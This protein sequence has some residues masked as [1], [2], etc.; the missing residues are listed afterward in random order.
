MGIKVVGDAMPKRIRY[1]SLRLLTLGLDTILRHSVADHVVF[2]SFRC[3][4]W[5][6][7]CEIEGCL[8]PLELIGGVGKCGHADS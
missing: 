6:S 8:S 3:V 5:V 1:D 2:E 4:E 7:E